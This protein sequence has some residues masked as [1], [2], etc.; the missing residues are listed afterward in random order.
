MLASMK[1]LLIKAQSEGYA[2]P[3][4]DVWNAEMLSGVMDAAEKRKSPVIL[5]FGS[6]FFGNV[7]F[8]HFTAMMVSMAKAAS[9]P[10]AIHWDHGEDIS[11]LRQAQNCGFNSVMLDCSALAFEEN[12]RLTKEAV[13]YFHARQIPVES[14][15]GH[16]GPE[17]DY[18]RA[19]ENYGFTDPMLAEEYVYRTGVDALAVAIGN[20]HGPY[21][22]EPRINFTIL[23]KVRASVSVP[24]VLH[25]ASGIS[26]ADI[27]TCIKLGISKINIHTELCQAAV[28]AIKPL[29]N[30]ES[31]LLA[32][33]LTIRT[34]VELRADEKIILFGS[35]N[36]A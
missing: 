29:V 6:G 12:V 5:A 26:D 28:E 21:T 34:A 3:N 35:N 1:D 9:V 8:V 18:E 20:A 24:L 13:E 31:S 23:E 15:L 27:K 2:V 19:M 11:L 14:E 7:D 33:G 17:M 4:F 16:I 10:V 36:K 22:S 25:G 32:I 30:K